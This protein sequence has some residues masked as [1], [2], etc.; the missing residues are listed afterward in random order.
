M[1]GWV[2]IGT[3]L[4]NKGIEQDLKK[5]Q[6]EL[7]KLEREEI[8]LKVK[9][10]KSQSGI[11]EYQK[12]IEKLKQATEQ[13]L[14][15]AVSD[16]QAKNVLAV[17]EQTLSLINSKYEKQLSTVSQIKSELE[18]NKNK[19]QS[20]TQSIEQTNNSLNKAKGLS[21][22]YDQ[23]GKSTSNIKDKM[24]SVISK[25]ARWGL[26]LFGVR[27]I[28]SGIRSLMST[29]SNYNEQ[30]KTDLEY[31]KFAIA[32]GFEGIIQ[33][34]IK[35]VF[36]ILQYINYIAMAW[37]GVNLF[38]K[39]SANNFNKVKGGIKGA[40]KEAKELQKTLTGFD[41]MN[42][43]NDSGGTSLGGGGGGM[44][45][46]DPSMDL[47]K[48]DVPIPEWLKWIGENKDKILSFFSALGIIIATFKLFKFIGEL[49]Q[50][51]KNISTVTNFISKLLGKLTLIKGLGIAVAL[52]GVGIAIKGIIDF[53]KDPSWDNFLTIL[54][55]V[56]VAVAGVALAM[57]G[58]AVA[59]GAGVVALVALVAKMT[60]Q[61]TESGKLKTA[62]EEL[63]QSEERL[64]RAKNDLRDATDDYILA[65]DRN[66]EAT[67]KLT[68][69]ERKHK[70][71]GEELQKQVD[72][73]TLSYEK[74]TTQQKEVY[75]AYVDSLKT[76]DTLADST[77]NLKDK[78]K[79]DTEAKIENT[80]KIKNQTKAQWEN[81]AVV[82][83]QTKSYDS[84]KTKV[85][86]AFK[87]GELS[88]EEAQDLIG[89]SMVTMS[90]GSEATFLKDIPDNIKKGFDP[91]QYR[92]VGNNLKDWANGVWT[93]IKKIFS[94]TITGNFSVSGGIS[95]GGGGGGGGSF[96]T[97]GLVVP[98]LATGGIINNPGRGVPLGR[99]IGGE[100]GSE[101]VIPLTD[102]QAMETLGQ[103]IGRYITL[104]LTNVNQ[105]NGRVL[106]R[107]IKKVMAND[108]FA[109][110]Y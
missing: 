16:E 47:S 9:L 83:S 102:S 74:M 67:K 87:R 8:K 6:S 85:V 40:N 22:I 17:E 72:N 44:S 79:E 1:D 36:T 98:R 95:S 80:E 24:S 53:I 48:I 89:R 76:Q 70:I 78:T 108:E 21:N 109:L 65:V 29:L 91:E 23:V 12:E 7:T 5:L 30:I 81:D 32:I 41:E 69:L 58:W 39:A 45:P 13:D 11:S 64:K 73:G 55:G 60:T 75:K 27:S 33:S 82:A 57:G 28:Y 43:I 62:N 34:I 10:D 51:G 106:S 90:K 103:A 2:K 38:A 50:M 100:A 52:I 93:S 101:G 54:I 61:N 46:I 68:E 42:I 107:E 20:I 92:T 59:I 96:A 86:E 19:Q 99:A 94:K 25:V 18:E 3:K 105:M 104:N 63:Q 56:A 49:G 14:K 97:G 66:E 26:A 31:V 35:G 71:S 37:F 84:F 88:A 77:T 4:D 15:L 110:N